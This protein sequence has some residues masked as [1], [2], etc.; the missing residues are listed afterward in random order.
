[1]DLHR[2]RLPPAATAHTDA[3]LLPGFVIETADGGA[4]I[5]T[6][7]ARGRVGLGT[8]SDAAAPANATT[9]QYGTFDRDLELSTGVAVAVRFCLV[10]RHTRGPLG[11]QAHAHT[12][13]H[14]HICIYCVGAAA[15]PPR[16]ARTLS[17]R[18]AL[19]RTPSEV[20]TRP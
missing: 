19:P 3:A 10:Y 11:H 20:S 1:M 4:V 17:E 15:L 9:V 5:A 6:V 2:C 18:P 12:H 8:V 14:T 7:D 16:H 13:T